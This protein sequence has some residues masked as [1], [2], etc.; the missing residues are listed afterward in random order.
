[1]EEENFQLPQKSPANDDNEQEENEETKQIREKMKRIEELKQKVQTNKRKTSQIRQDSAPLKKDIEKQLDEL[2]TNCIRIDE[3]GGYRVKKKYNRKPTITTA[4]NAVENILGV[5]A[6]IYVKEEMKKKKA[7]KNQKIKTLHILPTG[8]SRKRR[9]DKMPS[10]ERKKRDEELKKIR[11]QRRMEKK[12]K[13]KQEQALKSTTENDN[14]QSSG[15]KRKTG[16]GRKPL[17]EEEK[18]K[19]LE[20]KLKER[21]E[22]RKNKS[23]AVVFSKGSKKWLPTPDNKK[24]QKFKYMTG[25]ES[26]VTDKDIS[27]N[28]Q[29]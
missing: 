1:M 18:Q 10:P 14:N 9:K 17:S 13:E 26:I 6:L 5:Q 8:P 2:D 12:Q 22:K 28:T 29:E 19:R 15:T 27:S 23:T 3:F 21:E 7:E 11:Y 16:G 24:Y 4:Y 20:T 25:K